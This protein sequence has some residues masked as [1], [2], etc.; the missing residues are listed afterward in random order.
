MF[1]PNLQGGGA[2]RVTVNLIAGL[3][4]RGVA[5]EVVL[6]RAQGPLLAQL[7]AE[8]RVT[9]LGSPRTLQSLRPLAAWLRRA[10]PD[11]LLAVMDSA[12]TVAVAARRLARVPTR[13]VAVLHSATLMH[14][15]AKIPFG[16][17]WLPLALRGWLGGADA[18]V[19]VSGGA[20]AELGRL[21]PWLRPKI[22]TIYNPVV[23]EALLA[24]AQ[25]P[26]PH[27]WLAQGAPP[28]VVAVGRLCAAKDFATL[29]RAFALLSAQRPARLLIF[30]DGDL[31][32]A[33]QAQVAQ[34]GL[35]DRVQLPGWT[36][37]PW[38][39]LRCA[40]LFAL[41]SEYEA[42]PTVLIEALAC[43]TPAVA[44]D[45]RFGP[46]EV[47]QDGAFGALTPVGDAAALA[48]A[49]AATLD[50]PLPAQTLQA[51]AQAFSE[52][53]S[54]DQYL[55]LLLPHGPAAAAATPG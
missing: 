47:L 20:A 8:V 55:R 40:A 33:L 9:A 2:E 43:G 42:L 6:V 32:P 12:A 5:V 52:Q 7:P 38:A 41:S 27:P 25:E 35:G 37:N 51:R 26:P 21:F 29:L 28:V 36:D 31:R 54:V 10:R 3:V 34:L 11:A 19:A 16:E 46:R 48:A 39:A 14:A 15:T 17:R 18:I 50:R 53:S 30:G 49:M 13:V 45:C 44:T 22:H 24:K 4:R 23:T 1:I